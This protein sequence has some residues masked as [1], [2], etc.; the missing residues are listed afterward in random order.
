MDQIEEAGDNYF[1]KEFE[2]VY[3]KIIIFSNLL[4]NKQIAEN[5]VDKI[6]EK[7][8]KKLQET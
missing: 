6:K 2:I 4:E 8:L 7:I 1:N 5:F 3:Q